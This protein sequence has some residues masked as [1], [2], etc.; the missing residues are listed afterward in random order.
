MNHSLPF[1]SAWTV[2]IVASDSSFI[3]VTT[4]M[5]NMSDLITSV[6]HSLDGS[7]TQKVWSVNSTTIGI[8]RDI[9]HE[10]GKLILLNGSVA[11]PYIFIKW[12]IFNTVVERWSFTGISSFYKSFKRSDRASW[13]IFRGIHSL[14]CRIFTMIQSTFFSFFVV[15]FHFF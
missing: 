2:T 3:F 13:G 8:S 15:N 14:L 9:R 1:L 5:H 12:S 10:T 11:V 4:H 6:V 7:C